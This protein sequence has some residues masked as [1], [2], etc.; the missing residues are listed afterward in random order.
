M[1]HQTTRFYGIALL[2]DGAPKIAKMPY[3]W[4]NSMVY[5]CLWYTYIYIYIHI[6]IYTYIYIYITIVNGVYKPT[7]ITGGHHPVM[8]WPG[9]PGRPLVSSIMTTPT[10]G[11]Q[12]GGA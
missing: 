5:G 7:N 11:R 10:A 1:T 9:F 6:Y 8:L 3:K 12:V 4:L 2:Q